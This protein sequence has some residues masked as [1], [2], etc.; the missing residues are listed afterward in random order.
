M[1][2]F[3]V[4]LSGKQERTT[5]SIVAEH[6]WFFRMGDLIAKRISDRQEIHSCSISHTV[7]VITLT[8]RE[9]GEED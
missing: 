7:K 3:R 4:N 9:M 2:L 1:I 6:K 8:V 5:G